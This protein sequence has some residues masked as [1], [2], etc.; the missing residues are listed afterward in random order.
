[1]NK[2]VGIPFAQVTFFNTD[3][4]YAF[5]NEL[6]Y[7]D[8]GQYLDKLLS[9]KNIFYAV[10]ISGRF[11]YVKTRSVPKQAKPYPDLN[12]AVGEQKVFEFNNIEG[13]VDGFRSPEYSRNFRVGGYHLHFIG[14]DRKSGGHLL[15]F[16]ASGIKIE[17]DET[18]DF[19][20]SLPTNEEFLGL[21]LNTAEVR[22][23]SGE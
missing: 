12:Q 14:K 7:A 3:K 23:G 8:L 15:D 9:S 17:I 20:L 21:N 13:T 18:A 1:V 11:K 16:Q 5:D 2:A 19:Y 4:T 6:S 22:A 10:K